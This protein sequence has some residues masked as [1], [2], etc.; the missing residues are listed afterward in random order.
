MTLGPEYKSQDK[1]S[2][3]L[4]EHLSVTNCYTHT[5]F[6]TS[7]NLLLWPYLL[8]SNPLLVP[9]AFPGIPMLYVT[10][11]TSNNTRIAR[12]PRAWNLIRSGRI[13]LLIILLFHLRVSKLI[14]I[15][16]RNIESDF[17]QTYRRVS[18]LERLWFIFCTALTASRRKVETASR[19]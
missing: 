13:Y 10:C 17:A 6:P 15:G 19:R 5:P 3:I 4:S 16:Q 11:C 14:S 2:R 18:G 1:W 7:S 12:M 8:L 9:L